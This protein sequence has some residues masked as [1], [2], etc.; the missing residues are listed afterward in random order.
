[1]RG[2]ATMIRKT[3]EPTSKTANLSNADPNQ[4]LSKLKTEEEEKEWWSSWRTAM[5]TGEGANSGEPRATGA[6]TEE[7]KFCR[8][9]WRKASPGVLNGDGRA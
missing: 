4:N 1:M 3:L 6:H 5:C 2:E 9:Y 7:L 8:T